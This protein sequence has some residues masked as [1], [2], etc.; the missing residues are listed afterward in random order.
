M[1]FPTPADD[2]GRATTAP[3]AS[4]RAGADVLV[5][6]LRTS[7]PAPGTRITI[8]TPSDA[9]GQWLRAHLARGL[10]IA[11]GIDYAGWRHADYAPGWDRSTLTW[12]ILSV[13]PALRDVPH[14]PVACR[15]TPDEPVNATH[16]GDAKRIASMFTDYVEHDPALLQSLIAGEPAPRTDRDVLRWQRRCCRQLPSC[17]H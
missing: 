11:S 5:Q 10:G 3:A 12:A 2:D 16:L 1:S 9:S 13:G 8:A 15:R 17:C 7:P 4:I 14:A 6:H